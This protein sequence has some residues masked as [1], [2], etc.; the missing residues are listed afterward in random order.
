M[1]VRHIFVDPGPCPGA[2]GQ[3]AIGE[4]MPPRNLTLA[5]FYGTKQYFKEAA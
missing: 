1:R 2:E 5:I 4:G 3:R